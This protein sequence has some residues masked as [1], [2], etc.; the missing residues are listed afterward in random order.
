MITFSH[1]PNNAEYV[2]IVHDL[3]L[4]QDSIQRDECARAPNASTAMNDNGSMIGSDALSERPHKSCKSLRW[5]WYPE[6]GPSY[7][8]IVSNDALL[9]AAA[10]HELGD[11][12]IGILAVVEHLNLYVTVVHG[13]RVRWP[14]LVAF[15]SALFHATR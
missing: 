5:I 10:N 12:P 13:Y 11:N 2:D 8:V 6:I 4:L 1:G 14:I 3:D 7:K 15:L 9:I